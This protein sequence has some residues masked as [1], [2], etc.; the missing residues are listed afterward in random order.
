MCLETLWSLLFYTTLFGN[1]SLNACQLETTLPALL[2][3]TSSIPSNT[4][5]LGRV[6]GFRLGIKQVMGLDDD[7]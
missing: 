6:G 3:N 7:L 4:W 1:S 2:P 5:T